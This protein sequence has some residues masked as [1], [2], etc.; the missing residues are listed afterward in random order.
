MLFSKMYL[1]FL[2]VNNNLNMLDILF[3]IIKKEQ[4][5]TICDVS[6]IKYNII[7]MSLV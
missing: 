3:A 4:S 1:H 6:M 2:D 5:S 7:V